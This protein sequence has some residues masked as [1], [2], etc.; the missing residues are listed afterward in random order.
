VERPQAEPVDE[1]PLHTTEDGHHRGSEEEQAH[2]KG[3]WISPTKRIPCQQLD[4]RLIDKWRQ[5]SPTEPGN[6]C[7]IMARR[8]TLAGVMLQAAHQA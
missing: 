7:M 3:S 5:N 6:A 1:R 2:D 8:L 4:L